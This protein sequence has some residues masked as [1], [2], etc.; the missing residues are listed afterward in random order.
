MCLAVSLSAAGCGAA[1]GE[2]SASETA[3]ASA[4]SSVTE[5]S[6]SAVSSSSGS[7]S[8]ADR[9]LA[10]PVK[11]GKFKIADAITLGNYK[12]LNLTKTVQK[13]TEDDITSYIE[14]QMTPEEVTDKEAAAALGD[15]VDIAYEGKIDGKAFDGG[16]SDS[17]DLTLGSGSFIEGFE[18]GVVGMKKGETKDLN[19]RFP[20]DYFP[21]ILPERMSFLPSR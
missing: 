14:G 7:E 16:S 20:D 4:V 15:T 19:L 11:D 18:D 13:V 2:N 5:S 1:G 8:L 6:L 3:A 21:R 12:K 10:A 17:Y 9:I